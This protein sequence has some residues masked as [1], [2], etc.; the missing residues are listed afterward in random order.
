MCSFAE[1]ADVLKCLFLVRWICL[2][3]KALL[4]AYRRIRSFSDTQLQRTLRPALGG[5]CSF[6]DVFASVVFAHRFLDSLGSVRSNFLR[7][8]NLGLGVFVLGGPEGVCTHF[9]AL[10]IFVPFDNKQLI[11]ESAKELSLVAEYVETKVGNKMSSVM[12]IS[13][14]HETLNDFCPAGRRSLTKPDGENSACC[15]VQWSLRRL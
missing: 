8:R 4:V 10:Q 9:T 2:D 12:R 15:D 14:E 7:Y 1:A 5:A 3:L 13:E 6:Q 11:G